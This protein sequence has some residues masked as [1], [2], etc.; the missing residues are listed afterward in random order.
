MR[1]TRMLHLLAAV[2]L[3]ASCSSRP[4]VPGSEAEASPPQG[5]V[6][7]LIYFG[8]IILVP[9]VVIIAGVVVFV[10]RRRRA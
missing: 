4:S 3:A 9:G 8:A 2:L 7:N 10:R 6:L 5:Y 1:S